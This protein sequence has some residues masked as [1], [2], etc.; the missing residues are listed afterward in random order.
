MAAPEFT[1]AGAMTLRGDRVVISDDAF[2]G[3]QLR[4][5]AAMLLTDRSRPVTVDRI[6]EQVWPQ[7]P[8]AQFMPEL[9]GV[10]RDLG[11]FA[12]RWEFSE[13]HPPSRPW[14]SRAMRSEFTYHPDPVDSG[15]L[16]SG[17][18]TRCDIC[19]HTAGWI[20]DGPAYGRVPHGTVICAECISTGR[21][22]D[23]RDAEFT[24]LGG[25][26]WDAVPAQVKDEVLHRTPGFAG[27]QQEEW[28]AHCSDAM[29]FLGPMGWAE[30]EAAGPGAVQAL[31][32]WLSS[33]RW[34]DDQ[35]DDFLGQLSRQGMPTA[36]SFRCRHC[37]TFTAYADFT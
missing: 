24:D 9:T 4:L 32:D 21:A 18:G 10:R 28:R 5:V 31:R 22:A 33:W 13:G 11:T 8:P 14:R 35:V 2:G 3:R 26:G 16:R 17:D 23:E 36:Y 30:L 15:S 12:S 29:V 20:Y 7:G 34:T 27:W 1:V 25:D 37:G 19:G 6:V